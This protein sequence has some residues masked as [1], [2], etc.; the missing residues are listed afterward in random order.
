[1][2]LSD[3]VLG[4]GGMAFGG[5]I[6]SLTQGFPSLEGGH[7]GPALFP[8]ILAGLFIFFGLVLFIQETRKSGFSILT[9]RTAIYWPGFMNY[10]CVAV[11]VIVYMLLVDSLGFVLTA[12]LI[13]IL[14]MKKMGVSLLK[15]CLI[16]IVTSVS[17]NL[18]FG[19]F[20]LVPLPWGIL[21]W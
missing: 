8:R 5:I 7:P 18:L 3:S 12:I 2:K 10:L 20:L 1:M 21:G 13:L 14:L 4:L 6:L 15:S 9:H 11:A 16:A 19:K 17:I